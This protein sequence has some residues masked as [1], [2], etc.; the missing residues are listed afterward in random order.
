MVT[1]TIIIIY[2]VAL[3]ITIIPGPKKNG[4]ILNDQEKE[5]VNKLFRK[6]QS[7][8]MLQLKIILC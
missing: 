4:R 8:I 7:Q 1:L 6:M 5:G 2:L 3:L